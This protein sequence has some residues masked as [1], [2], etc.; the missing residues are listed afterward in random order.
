MLSLLL[1]IGILMLHCGMHCQPTEVQVELQLFPSSTRPAKVGTDVGQGF[2]KGIGNPAG[3][4]ALISELVAA[5]LGTWFN[6]K[7]PPFAI[8][9][10]CEI[11]IPM[12]NHHGNILPPIFFSKAIEG[13]PRDGGST[14]LE[15]LSDKSDVAKLVVFDTWIRNCDRYIDGSANSDNLF[16][17]TAT[18]GRKYDLVPIDHSHC[19]V[20][21]DFEEL[22]NS[23][24]IED[25]TIYGLYPEFCEYIT[26]DYVAIAINKLRELDREFVKDCVNSIPVEWNMT[27]NCRNHLVDLICQRAEYVV[28]TISSKL[29]D[30]PHFC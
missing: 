28:N 16:Y 27:T 18:K 2:I 1:S 26:S 29:V 13:M 21:I 15:R 30:D 11:A 7:I 14:F 3:D 12:I 19:F 23:E 24:F 5:E 4:T 9:Q 8:I 25:E 6:L 17:A 20:D 10:N 22:P